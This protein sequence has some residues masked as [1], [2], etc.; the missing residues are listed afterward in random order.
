MPSQ[1]TQLPRLILHRSRQQWATG[2]HHN[3]HKKQNLLR[4][5]NLDA[6]R[7]LH[8]HL[9]LHLH[10]QWWLRQNHTLPLMSQKR[11]SLNKT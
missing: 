3:W 2:L 11:P 7:Y 8:L 9:H 10:L 4:R 6:R 1:N 5:K